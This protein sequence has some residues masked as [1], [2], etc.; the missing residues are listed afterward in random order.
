MQPSVIGA[1][2]ISTRISLA[3]LQ[4]PS[5]AQDFP[6][7]QVRLVVPYP[8]GG[9][10]DAVARLVAE[11]LSREWG[12][13]VIVENKAGANGNLGGEYVAK[14]SPDGYTVLFSPSGVYTTAKLLYPNLPFDPD[15]DLQAV[16]LAAVTPNVIMVTP[17]LPISTLQELVAYAKATPGQ[18]TYASQGIGS[19]AHL[20]A[21]YLA[22]V[23]NLDLRHIPYRGAAPA[24]TDVVAGHVTMTVDGLSS[25][26]GIIRNGT[27]RPLAV[28]SRKR[29]PVLPDVPTAIEAGFP[30]FE[31][32]SWY[33]V[34]VPSGTPE[35]VIQIL[36]R[37]IS[38]ALHAPDIMKNLVEHGADVVGSS[39]AELAAYVKED[40]A[41][42][43]KVIDD[44]K[45]KVE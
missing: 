24:L 22:Q 40:T 29:S 41:R 32:A 18:V 2:L 7:R 17:K 37:A 13:P 6:A 3:Y 25:A 10:V 20:T 12:H 1:L 16:T 30:N 27:L 31:S 9:G 39:P 38:R 5:C 42:W 28:A 35:P 33:G 14:S 8:A 26:L 11:R 43:K 44:A 21:A 23:A 36:S 15:K 19:T 45:I 34:T 4:T